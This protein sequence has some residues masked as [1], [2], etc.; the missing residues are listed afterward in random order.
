MLPVELAS[1]STVA[2]PFKKD[3]AIGVYVPLSLFW[4]WCNF[5]IT[6]HG[7]IAVQRGYSIIE[8]AWTACCWL[9]RHESLDGF[10]VTVAAGS[11]SHYPVVDTIKVP[12]TY[13]NT[14]SIYIGSFISAIE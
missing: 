3:I 13:I 4:S 14:C 7:D 2:F 12:D 5:W 8:S 6:R 1:P 9:W 10:I 11:C